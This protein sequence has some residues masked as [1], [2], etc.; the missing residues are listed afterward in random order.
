MSRV[1]RMSPGE[2]W[3]DDSYEPGA[4][5]GYVR[6]TCAAPTA[7]AWEVR[8]P[9]Y[10]VAYGGWTCGHNVQVAVENIAERSVADE[11]RERILASPDKRLGFD[12]LW[13]EVRDFGRAPYEAF[14]TG[15]E[16]WALGGPAYGR[17]G[18]IV[19][20]N[21]DHAAVQWEGEPF[22]GGTTYPLHMMATAP[23]P[24]REPVHYSMG[25][26]RMP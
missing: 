24:A 17:K 26:L 22:T 13:A 18:S 20:R 25:W 10:H 6:L 4:E 8:F 2:F 16:F 23:P 21:R 3:W 7:D 11:I 5:L 9:R 19:I 1:L 12:D 14:D 15:A